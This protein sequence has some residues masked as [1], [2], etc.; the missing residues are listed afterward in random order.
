MARSTAEADAVWRVHDKALE[1]QFIE[2]INIQTTY[3]VGANDPFKES[4]DELVEGL[5]QLH[6]TFGIENF[7]LK[8]YEAIKKPGTAAVDEF[9]AKHNIDDNFFRRARTFMLACFDR[10]DSEDKKEVTV[11]YLL[12]IVWQA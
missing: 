4:F 10:E 7:V 1:T 8:Y 11:N 12:S 5:R 9:L 3:C 6:E 2:L